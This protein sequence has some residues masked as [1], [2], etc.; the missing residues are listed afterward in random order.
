MLYKVY[1]LYSTSRNRLF[2]GMTTSLGEQMQIF[3]GDQ[4]IEGM[5][6]FKP[7]TLVH[8]EL[9]NNEAEAS[10]RESFLKSPQG[11]AYVR[12]DILSLFGF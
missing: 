11:Q 5:S 12:S 7:W 8:M 9:F 3:N 1:V 2:T 6:E 4:E 10:M